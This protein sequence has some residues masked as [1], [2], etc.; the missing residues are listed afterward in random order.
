MNRNVCSILNDG[1]ELRRINDMKNSDVLYIKEDAFN[2]TI[3]TVH[4]W[5]GATKPNN[6]YCY[7]LTYS[8][9]DGMKIEKVFVPSYPVARWIILGEDMPK[10]PNG[11]YFVRNGVEY[12]QDKYKDMISLRC[13]PLVTDKNEYDVYLYFDEIFYAAN[14]HISASR[15]GAV[16][17][18]ICPSRNQVNIG[19]FAY[20]AVDTDDV[21]VTNL[22]QIR[23]NSDQEKVL[24][25]SDYTFVEYN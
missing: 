6:E 3:M 8:D 15:I 22:T 1:F 20:G 10:Y 24:R 25:V 21:F 16:H 12:I 5:A 11:L 9:I 7:R 13:A 18:S 14:S 17:P 23:Y 19:D 2:G 4:G